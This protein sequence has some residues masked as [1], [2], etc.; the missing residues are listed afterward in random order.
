M[1][2]LILIFLASIAL[3]AS[4]DKCYVIKF[5]KSWE[6]LTIKYMDFDSTCS[7]KTIS[8]GDMF[9]FAINNT[10]CEYN[11]DFYDKC[12]NKEIYNDDVAVYV[13][14]GIILS[15]IVGTGLIIAG[16][17]IYIVIRYKLEDKKVFTFKV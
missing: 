5:M 16:Y 9:Q 4:A 17:F 12:T 10:V 15:I 11:K 14:V 1:K 2:V 3:A 6:D 8:P 7:E 13:I